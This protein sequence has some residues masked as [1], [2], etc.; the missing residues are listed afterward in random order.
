MH[1]THPNACPST[2]ALT[3]MRA[4]V[5]LPGI[6]RKV[7]VSEAALPAGG[8]AGMLSN[9]TEGAAI[10]ASESLQGLTRLSITPELLPDS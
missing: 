3:C 8:G 1:D 5:P 2:D 9:Q 7:I 4:M 6:A 10:A